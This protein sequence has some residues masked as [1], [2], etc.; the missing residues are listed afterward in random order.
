M[1]CSVCGRKEA[2]IYQRHTGRAL[3][4]ECFTEDIVRRVRQEIERHEMFKGSDRVL[5]A[6]SGGKD[7]YTLLNVMLRIHDPSRLGIVTIIEG[8]PG[9]NREGDIEWVLR[10]AR[11]H[12]VDVV[13]TSYK[14][15]VGYSMEELVN[16][17]IEKGVRVTPCTFCGFLRRRIINKYAREGG[18][19][20]VA[21]AHNLDDE[22]HTSLMNL[23]RG[24]YARLAQMH[25]KAP[26]LSKLFVKKVKPLRKIYEWE[27]AAYAW[28]TGYGF[29][30]TEC[31]YLRLRPSFRARVRAYM[32]E[33][34][35]EVPGSMLK[36]LE[37]IDRLAEPLARSVSR[38]PE[39]P[40]CEVCGEPTSYNR[41]VCAFC[42][43]MAMIGAE[44][45]FRKLGTKTPAVRT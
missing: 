42:D 16:L 4:R 8:I 6:L 34:E 38:L 31:P 45:Y 41:R 44:E 36:F 3:C 9:Y 13:V 21:T 23:L 27:S 24:D 2:V 22:A 15:E 35:R 28:L 20:R 39:L 11:E 1:R 30:E 7:S 14:E 32:Y 19:D 40:R 43:L 5:L 37:A 12:G 26:V 18:Y 29:Q 10:R 25:P 33:L 17:T